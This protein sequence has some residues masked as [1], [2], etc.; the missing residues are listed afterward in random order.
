MKI[1]VLSVDR[2]DDF[3]VKAGMNSPFIGRLRRRPGNPAIAYALGKG[4]PKDVVEACKWF[5][6]AAAHSDTNNGA[7]GACHRRQT[8]DPGAACRGRK[9]RTTSCRRIDRPRPNVTSA[10]LA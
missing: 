10:K 5:A 7:D 2:D 1:L 6:L 3:G 4:V 9:T 8:N